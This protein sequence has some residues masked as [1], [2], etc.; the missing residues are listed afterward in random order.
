MSNGSFWLRPLLLTKRKGEHRYAL[1]NQASPFRNT[2]KKHEQ[3]EWYH[4]S[5]RVLRPSV[6]ESKLAVAL[7]LATTARMS[8][9]RGRA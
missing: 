6:A 7:S 1:E 5:G 9:L 8:C 4:I 3:S 2:I